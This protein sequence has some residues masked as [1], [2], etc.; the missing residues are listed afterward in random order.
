LSQLNQQLLNP[1]SD[2]TGDGVFDRYDVAHLKN[3]ISEL[4]NIELKLTPEYRK[5]MEKER[6]LKNLL[7]E[8]NVLKTNAEVNKLKTNSE[9]LNI[10]N[11][12][13][14]VELDLMKKQTDILNNPNASD[15]DKDNAMKELKILLG[16]YKESNKTNNEW[17]LLLQ[18]A[19]GDPQKALQLKYNQELALKSTG[20][21][22]T[23]NYTT[24]GSATIDK[25][26]NITTATVLGVPI[27]EDVIK[28]AAKEG[29][30][31]NLNPNNGELV[32]SNA[33]DNRKVRDFLV[34]LGLVKDTFWSIQGVDLTS[35]VKDNPNAKFEGS[36]LAI[37]IDNWGANTSTSSN[38]YNPTYNNTTNN[39]QVR[40]IM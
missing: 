16:K 34:K 10:Q 29:V 28:M 36:N 14:K 15:V 35:F 12:I 5:D 30:V 20:S 9:V 32:I 19:G 22:S 26:G 33:W 7:A 25:D 6:E 13:D 2:L 23:V 37:K 1:N 8:A 17:E 3:A 11:Q 31:M 18:A 21:T 24:N 27:T 39:N 40:E 38:N 4:Q